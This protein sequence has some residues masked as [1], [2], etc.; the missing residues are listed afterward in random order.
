M[1]THDFMYRCQSEAVPGRTCCEERLEDPRQ[2][3]LVHA[4]AGITHRYAH[5]SAPVKLALG[6]QVPA[7]GLL[8]LPLDPGASRIFPSLT[9][10][11]A[12]TSAI[13]LHLP[14]VA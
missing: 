8:P 2:S 10:V 5:I 1:V 9:C 11:F 3:E 13:F 4:T 14:R 12:V 6:E 7:A